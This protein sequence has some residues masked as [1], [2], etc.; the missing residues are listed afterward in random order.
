MSRS[1][2]WP[3]AGVGPFDCALPRCHRP[4]RP[5]STGRNACTWTVVSHEAFVYDGWNMVMSVNLDKTTGA[6]ASR[7]ATY[8]WGP[9]LGSRGDARGDWQRAGGVG[10]LLMVLGT[11]TATDYFPL[12]DRMGNIVGY[13]RADVS[14]NAS[15]DH[16]R[17]SQYGAVYDYDA[18]GREVR[19]AGP[20]A[21]SIPFHFSSKFTDAETGLNYYG[22]RFYDPVAGRWLNRDPIGERGGNNL[23]KFV[24]NIPLSRFDRMGLDEMLDA[25]QAEREWKQKAND[26]DTIATDL[27]KDQKVLEKRL[28]AL[29]PEKNAG[30]IHDWQHSEFLNAAHPENGTEVMQ[31]CTRDNCLKQAKKIAETIRK[32]VEEARRLNKNHTTGISQNWAF[33]TDV[34]NGSLAEHATQGH[35][36]RCGGW[37][38]LVRKA[39]NE[40]MQEA[41]KNGEACFWYWAQAATVADHSWG[42]LYGP[43]K[44]IN[45]GN[46]EEGGKFTDNNYPDAP[47]TV[48]P[49]ESGG[50]HLFS[51]YLHE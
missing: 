41:T 25:I 48:D 11:A 16:N 21:D 14:P 1:Y 37:E 17:L 4:E 50:Q 35:G 27:D 12:H 24:S 20:A 23:F 13:R 22:Y 19:S 39:F 38:D 9:D 43:S 42:G 40:A 10:G 15:T 7:A 5:R 30:E 47:V 45:T 18:F 2:G 28:A 6:V 36:L 8:V 33:G 46:R 3:V 44:P 26:N 29:C 34:Q 51:D 31:C 49:W 32:R